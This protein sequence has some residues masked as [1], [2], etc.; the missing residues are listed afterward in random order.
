MDRQLLR[1]SSPLEPGAD[2]AIDAQ[3][4]AVVWLQEATRNQFNPAWQH[5]SSTLEN[6]LKTLRS[7][8]LTAEVLRALM[9][10]EQRLGEA[11]ALLE[12]RLSRADSCR[13]LEASGSE[14]KATFDALPA[15]DWLARLEA[16]AERWLGAVAELLDSHV[17]PPTAV[18]DYRR[19]WLSLDNPAAPLPAYREAL[20]AH[21]HHWQ[22]LAE[23]C[24]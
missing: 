14:L 12:E 9:L 1:A 11:N 3:L 13:A 22:I 23:R 15:A 4:D 21:R 20:E 8:P 6:H 19:R 7:R 17:E 2:T 16:H 10:A 18:A 24:P 5:D